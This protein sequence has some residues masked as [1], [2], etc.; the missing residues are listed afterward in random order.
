MD[1]TGVEAYSKM[2]LPVFYFALFP[3]A[4]H[5]EGSIL[6]VVETFF[7]DVSHDLACSGLA[8]Q[9]TARF[10]PDLIISDEI[11]GVAIGIDEAF[12]VN[13]FCIDELVPREATF[14]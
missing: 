14:D 13:N 5:Q 2:A 3:R 7:K 8:D 6:F 1:F 12:P 9:G 10:I 4:R 11:G